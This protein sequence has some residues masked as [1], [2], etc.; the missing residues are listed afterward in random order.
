MT[1]PLMAAAIGNPV[2]LYTREQP[3]SMSESSLTSEFTYY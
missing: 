2:Q 1:T 3:L